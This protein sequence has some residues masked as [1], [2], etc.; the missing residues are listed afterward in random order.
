MKTVNVG[1]EEEDW[2]VIFNVLCRVVVL[3]KVIF[4]INSGVKKYINFKYFIQ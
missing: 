3:S 2:K 1:F 4:A